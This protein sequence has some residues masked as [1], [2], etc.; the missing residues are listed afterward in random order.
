VF[1]EVSRRVLAGP[2]TCR[3]ATRRCHSSVSIE[4]GARLAGSAFSID[5]VCIDQN[6][7]PE[8][9]HQVGLMRQ[10]YSLAQNTIIHLGDSNDECEKVMNAALQEPLDSHLRQ[11]AIDQILSRPWFTRVWIYQELVLSKDPWAQCGRRRIRWDAL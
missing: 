11:L 6:N 5:R 7:I 9:N 3:G 8:R 2:R 10:I 4:L 1:T